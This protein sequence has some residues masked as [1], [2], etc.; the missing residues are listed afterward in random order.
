MTNGV[1]TAGLSY[2]DPDT[3]QN[4]ATVLRPVFDHDLSE[5]ARS[6]GVEILSR[7]TA[8]GLIKEEGKI[9]GVST[10]KGPI[11][12]D[13][14]FLAEGDAAH[15]VSKEGYSNLPAGDKGHYLQGIKKL[16]TSLLLKLKSVLKSTRAKVALMK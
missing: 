3:Y 6:K 1:D 14:V 9:I 15:L 7:T 13:L 10:E 8:I 2:K 4:C 12:S 5:I 11:Y 16:F